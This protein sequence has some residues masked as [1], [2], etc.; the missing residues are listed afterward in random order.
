MRIEQKSDEMP[1]RDGFMVNVAVPGF[2][3]FNG[4]GDQFQLSLI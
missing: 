4:V 2:T 3:D 1:P